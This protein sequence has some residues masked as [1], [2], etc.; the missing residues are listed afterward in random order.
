MSGNGG[1][2]LLILYLGTRWD[3]GEWSASLLGR[4]TA[5]GRTTVIRY[6]SLNA[7]VAQLKNSPFAVNTTIE[8]KNIF[9][10]AQSY[11]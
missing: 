8:L 9:F 7:I 4:F 10:S 5:R 3:G 1:I 6:P 11:Y 2:A